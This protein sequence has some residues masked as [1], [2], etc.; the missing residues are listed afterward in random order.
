MPQG[1]PRSQ[2]Q[3]SSTILPPLQRNRNFPQTTNGT[4][5]R[6]YFEQASHGTTPILPSQP[7][8]T[9][10]AERYAATPG[11]TAFDHP[12]SSNGTPR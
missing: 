4:A 5:A 12:G 9:N 10:E 1:Y 11:A 3:A 8:A 7:I 2:Y 6:G